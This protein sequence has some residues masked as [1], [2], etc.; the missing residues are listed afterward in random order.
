MSSSST[1][2]DAPVSWTSGDLPLRI[3]V[4]PDADALELA[5]TGG[6][7]DDV[8]AILRRGLWRRADTP[9][10]GF[11]RLEEYDGD[12][13]IPVGVVNETAHQA[14]IYGLPPCHLTGLA[15]S[16]SSTTVLAIAAGECMDS[17]NVI[18]ISLAAFTKSTAGAWAAGSAGNGMG[19]GLTIANST[20]YHVF[21]IINAGLA[22][23]YFDTS[24]SAANAPSGT[25][26]F[27]RIGSFKT[28]GSA[29]IIDFVQNG[30]D[31]LLKTPLVALN[32]TTG[33]VTTFA[34]GCPTGVVMKVRVNVLGTVGSAGAR[35]ILVYSP[36]QNA[37]TPNTPAGNM[38]ISWGSS[39]FQGAASVEIWTDTS[40]QIVIAP[41]VSTNLFA[42]L[43]GWTDTRGRNG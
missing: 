20:S 24:A 43:V 12:T 25:T 15:L 19:D 36:Q 3:F 5:I 40:G 21:A 8:P 4:A 6:L 17:T 11:S 18:G 34:T 7:G 28:D 9:A 2:G 14:T 30:D 42:T 37:Q 31:F 10:A 27:R 13:S 35:N 41:G 1:N 23:V 29:Q 16:R 38:V 22:D 26:H 32:T 33:S 39:D